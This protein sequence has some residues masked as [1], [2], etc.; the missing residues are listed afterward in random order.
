VD[1]LDAEAERVQHAP[2]LRA[3][4]GSAEQPFHARVAA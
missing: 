3:L 2:R 1:L 4:H